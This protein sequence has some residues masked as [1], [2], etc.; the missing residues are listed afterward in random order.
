[1]FTGKD[2][3]F[4]NSKDIICLGVVTASQNYSLNFNHR[5]KLHTP[6]LTYFETLVNA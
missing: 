3:Q 5:R 6:H 4:S 1:M 2:T